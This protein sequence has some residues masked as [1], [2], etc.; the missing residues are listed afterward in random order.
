MTW[1]GVMTENGP[2]GVTE[3]E[4]GGITGIGGWRSE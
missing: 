3:I 1:G 4:G 2:G